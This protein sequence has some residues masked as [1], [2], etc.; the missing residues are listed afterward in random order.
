MGRA[1][2]G[3]RVPF[4]QDLPC[5]TDSMWLRTKRT[6]EKTDPSATTASL[7]QHQRQQ[8]DG[9]RPAG[10]GPVEVAL[11][12]KGDLAESVHRLKLRSRATALQGSGL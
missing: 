10:E 5:C 8:R 11:A 2:P 1:L 4:W 9:H 12:L 6:E 3:G 7:M